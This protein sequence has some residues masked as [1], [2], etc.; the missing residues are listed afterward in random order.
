[1]SFLLRD[2]YVIENSE[3]ERGLLGVRGLSISWEDLGEV[4]W[5]DCVKCPKF[6]GCDE[7]AMVL[8]KALEDNDELLVRTV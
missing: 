4:I 8:T 1:M 5:A 2:F 6:P 7:I 3:V